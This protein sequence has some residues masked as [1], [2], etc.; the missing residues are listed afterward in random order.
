MPRR[1][2]AYTLS[3]RNCS[4]Y[5][6]TGSQVP[7]IRYDVCI[8]NKYIKKDKHFIAWGLEEAHA[9]IDKWIDIIQ[10]PNWEGPVLRA[11]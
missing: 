10:S 7:Y 4:I 9:I 5:K 8:K 2:G 1:C 6:A 11:N 3:Y